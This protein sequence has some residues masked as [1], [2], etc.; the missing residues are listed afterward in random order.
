MKKHRQII[1]P[2]WTELNK[3]LNN[4]LKSQLDNYLLFSLLHSNITSKLREFSWTEIGFQIAMKIKGYD[5]ET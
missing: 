5:E 4:Q 1:E 3:A 2:S